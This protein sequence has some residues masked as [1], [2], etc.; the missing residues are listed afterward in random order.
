MIIEITNDPHSFIVFLTASMGIGYAFFNRNGFGLGKLMV[1]V[2]IGGPLFLT[3][4]ERHHMVDVSL[5]LLIGFLHAKEM[6]GAIN[7]FTWFSGLL[8]RF[9]WK[10][11]SRKH[12]RE[13][14]RAQTTANQQYDDFREQETRK[15][16]EQ[17]KQDREK[18]KRKKSSSKQNQ[19]KQSNGSANSNQSKQQGSSSNNGY[20][21]YKQSYQKPKPKPPSERDKALAVLGLEPNATMEE[22]KRARSKLMSL[23][24]PDKLAGLP[25]GRRK[26]AEEEAKK[27]NIAW[28]VIKQ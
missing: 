7:P 2:F 12:E 1:L 20:E 9:K 11:Q 16:Q 25:E 18:A 19:Q 6:I 14:A 27:I 23:Y 28:S 17:A 10:M 8:N 22:A 4:Y 15:R 24:H 26:Q 3:A 13:E 21:Q 5:G